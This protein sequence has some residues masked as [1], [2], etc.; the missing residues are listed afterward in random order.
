MAAEIAEDIAASGVD[1]F[2]GGGRD[3][4][5]RRKDGRNLTD[6]LRRRG[7]VIAY[8]MDEVKGIERGRLAAML[9]PKNQKTMAEGRGDMLPE[10]TAQALQILKNN[11]KKGFF[12]MVEGSMIDSGGHAN[13]ARMVTDEG[14]DFWSAVALAFDFADRNQG[15]L[16]VVTADHETGGLTLPSG[17]ADFLSADAGIDTKFGATGHTAVMV[18]VYSY[19][20]GAAAFS[21]VM[22]NTDIFRKMM[23]ALRLGR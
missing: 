4:F 20:A 1:L 9:A 3:N 19:G 16:V 10:A 15:T 13:D 2:I 11:N 14:D 18:P 6:S 5:E 17:N 8:T 23:A 22:D 7:Y 12:L 21:A